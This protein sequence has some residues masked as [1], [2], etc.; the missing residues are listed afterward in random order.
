MNIKRDRLR[1]KALKLGSHRC[2][3]VADVQ[4]RE[5][6]RCRARKSEDLRRDLLTAANAA[7]DAF[8]GSVELRLVSGEPSDHFRRGLDAH[9]HLVDLMR[10]HRRD[11]AQGAE[12]CRLLE[13]SG[14]GVALS[15]ITRI[16]DDLHLSV[17]CDVPAGDA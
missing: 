14:H 5:L 2:E 16:R 13:R 8:S 7:Q 3:E 1:Q 12:P 4:Q 17:I 9:Q 6:R 10:D 15:D 11:A